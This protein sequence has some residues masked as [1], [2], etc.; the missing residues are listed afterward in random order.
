MSVE[1]VKEAL[2]Q[3]Q[4]DVLK[5]TAYAQ[6]PAALSHTPAFVNFT[7]PAQYDYSQ[8]DA[9]EITRRY[10]MR[11]YLR[12]KGQGIDGEAERLAE[13]W[14]EAVVNCFSARRRLGNTQFVKTSRLLSDSGLQVAAYAGQ[15][16]LAIDFVIEVM[17]WAEVK[18]VE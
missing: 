9:V 1:T 10:T 3:I 4:S 5:V 18:Y 7:G 13:P 14:F 17:E 15:D 11:L 2:A 8:S 6:G 12:E 16:Y